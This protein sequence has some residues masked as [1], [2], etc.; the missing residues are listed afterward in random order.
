VRKVGY[1]NRSPLFPTR[2]ALA[3]YGQGEFD[4]PYR[5]TVPLLSWLRHDQ[6]MVRSLFRALG[7][8]GDCGVHLEYQ[9]PPPLGQ[10]NASH[11]DL[12]V[13]AGDV[14]LAVEAKW[15]ETPYPTVGA[16]LQGVHPENGPL[17]LR[18]W[19]DL[20]EKHSARRLN[21]AEFHPATYQMVH[22]AASACAAGKTPVLAYLLFT[23]SPKPNTATPQEIAG[24]LTLLR[25]LL[26]HPSGYPFFLVEI[27]LAPTA[28][29]E[30]LEDQGAAEVKAAI[31]GG[32]PLFTFKNYSVQAI[33]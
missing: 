17:V 8:V 30:G 9:V 1:N 32:D 16:W 14:A 5:S 11:T 18:G 21:Q 10:G 15:T 12:M 24:Q 22:R 2:E 27:D 23:Q 20:L 6:R 13:V 25:A 26:G 4:S 3:C 29:F 28:R 7:V 33:L 19:L 31:E